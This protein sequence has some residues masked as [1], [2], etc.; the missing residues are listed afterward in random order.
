MVVIHSLVEVSINKQNTKSGSLDAA[1]AV[2]MKRGNAGM[3]LRES[4]CFGQVG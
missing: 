1:L 4:S 3:R 2:K